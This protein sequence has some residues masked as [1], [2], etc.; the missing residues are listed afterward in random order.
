MKENHTDSKEFKIKSFHLFKLQLWL[1]E[2]FERRLKTVCN[3]KGQPPVLP[4]LGGDGNKD[5][6]HLTRPEL[7]TSHCRPFSGSLKP[8]FI[9]ALHRYGQFK[10]VKTIEDV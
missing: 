2:R 4:S 6:H 9:S 8:Q 1:R 5:N 7:A 10:T 3:G